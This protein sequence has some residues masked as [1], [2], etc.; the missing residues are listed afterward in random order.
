[1]ARYV[2]TKI[3]NDNFRMNHSALATKP[4]LFEYITGL[5]N[6]M[7]TTAGHK[8]GPWQSMAITSK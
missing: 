3:F 4:L 1:M 2:V 8:A 5:G 6:A 7:T